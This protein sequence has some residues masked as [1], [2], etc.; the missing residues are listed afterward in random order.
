LLANLKWCEKDYDLTYYIAEFWNSLSSI[1]ICIIGYIGYKLHPHPSFNS[2]FQFAFLSICIVGIGS[3]WFHATLS[4]KGQLA[5][6]LPMLVCAAILVH[7]GVNTFFGK[8]PKIF[9]YALILYTIFTLLVTSLLTGDWQFRLFHST[10][11][12]VI[13]SKRC[14]FFFFS[15][16]NSFN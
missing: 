16:D 8:Q 10:F 5:D 12:Y 3:A 9:D 2:K 13:L 15:S 6:E 11:L 14:I 4:R 7:L 1:I